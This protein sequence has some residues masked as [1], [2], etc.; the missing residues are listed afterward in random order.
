M[1]EQRNLHGDQIVMVDMENG[2]GIDY[3]WNR[4]VI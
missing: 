1:A 3:S 4:P 2:V